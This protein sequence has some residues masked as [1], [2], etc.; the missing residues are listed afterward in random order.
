[1]QQK[2]KHIYV[3]I[4]VEFLDKNDKMALLY[5]V[6]VF[7]KDLWDSSILQHRCV[8]RNEKPQDRNI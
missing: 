2:K 5:I 7:D 4:D 6:V 8:L 3:Y 1:M